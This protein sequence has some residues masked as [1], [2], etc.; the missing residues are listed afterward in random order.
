M[1]AYIHGKMFETEMFSFWSNYLSVK[2]LIAA[3]PIFYIQSG[4][5]MENLQ[6]EMDILQQMIDKFPKFNYKLP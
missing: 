3:F 2:L 5:E 1:H 4:G 6:V